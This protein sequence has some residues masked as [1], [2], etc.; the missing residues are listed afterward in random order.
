MFS[1]EIPLF[2]K[3]IQK[4]ITVENFFD[5]FF[6]TKVI[7]WND[8]IS[9]II[10]FGICQEDYDLIKNYLLYLGIISK[11]N[12]IEIMGKFNYVII[13]WFLL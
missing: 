6:K 2:F 10:K 8:K 12:D 13:Y 7:D 5:D 9:K 11:V 3:E 4:N 1:K